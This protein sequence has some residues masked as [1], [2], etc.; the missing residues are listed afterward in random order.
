MMQRASLVTCL[1]AAALV[2][3]VGCSKPASPKVAADTIYFGGPIIT[4][5]DAQPD[6]E[7]IAVANGRIVAVGARARIERDHANAATGRV[8]LGGHALLPGFIDAHTHMAQV[9]LQ[10]LVANLLPPPDGPGASI[11]QLQQALRDYMAASPVVQQNGVVI[12]MGYDDSQLVE[13][14][15]PTREELDAVSTTLPVFV[16]HQ[17]GHLGAYNSA[18]LARAGVTAESPDPPGGVIQRAADGRSPNGVLEEV[19]H[20][21]ALQANLPKFT[22]A[23]GL[24]L[25]DAAQQVYARYG[26]TT[27][28][29]GRAMPDSVALFEAAAAAGKLQLDVI[30]YPDMVMNAD[31][32][33]LSGPLMSRS[34]TNHLRFGGV[35]LS[36]D[37]SPQGKTAYFSQPYYVV[38]A[39]KPADYRGY[40]SMPLAE[41]TDW[42]TRAYRHGWQVM[43]HANGDAAI[44]QLI[45]SVRAAEDSVPGSDRRTVLV[46]GQYLRRDQIPELAAL[47]ILPSLYPMHTFYWGDWHRES[48]AGP[49]RASNISPTGWVLAAG[50]KFTIHDDAPVTFP[51]SLR[52]LDSA[53]NR[54]TRSGFVLGPE[55]RLDP[56]TALKAMTL[57]S[58][59]QY[60]EEADKGSL[61]VGKRADLVV[62][63]DNPL[64]VARDKLIELD[65]VTTIK[66]G[67]VVYQRP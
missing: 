60:F 3:L 25:L 67:A 64:T 24:A 22:P 4:M 30:V 45:D 63:S 32:P 53:V 19:A 5:N 43:V 31:N 52:V 8:D 10:A 48:V 55:Q 40:P 44:D 21:A 54:T 37:G 58:A 49:A 7:A 50:Q 12:G 57:W 23:Q 6:A 66:D 34:Y 46:H 13:H 47:G 65:V 42:I 62:L 29:E 56:L 9:G 16:I 27:V 38:P 36:L 35:K 33:A 26:F 18:A 1:L 28:E 39:G 20:F 61:E 2:C 59:Y 11:E 41:S 17:S 14:R 15:A 51:N